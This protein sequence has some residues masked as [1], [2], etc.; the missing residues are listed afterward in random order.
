MINFLAYNFPYKGIGNLKT[1]LNPN[2][3]DKPIATSEIWKDRFKMILRYVIYILLIIG[4]IYVIRMM[5][6]RSADLREIRTSIVSQGP[7]LNTISATGTIIPASEQVLTA[8]IEGVIRKVHLTPGVA[9]KSGDAIIELDKEFVQLAYESLKD[10]LEVRKNKV[11]KLNLEFEKNI[12]DLELENKIKGLKLESLETQLKDAKKLEDIGGVTHEEVEKAELDLQIANLEKLQLENDLKFRKA[13]LSSD[14]RNLELDIAIQEKKIRELASKLR[15][16]EIE[17]P[18]SS[19]IT[20]VNENIGTKVSEGEPLVRL[21]DLNSFR[22]EASSSDMHAQQIKIN[23]PVKVRIDKEEL[24]GYISRILPEVENNTIKFEVI[25][26]DPQSDLLKANLRVEVFIIKD[27]KNEALRVVNGPVFRGTREQD[28]FIKRR[29][30]AIKQRVKVG[31][32]NLDYVEILEGV[33]KGDT[34]I[35]SELSNYQHL[36]E[37]I[38]K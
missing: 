3:M 14:Q 8:P 31:I 10:E 24:D 16:S 21:A 4:A 12:N 11:I 33:Q 9:V 22:I 28:I 13:S 26:T 2:L 20:W 27:Q 34:I 7:I 17:A 30:K 37:F 18:R 32:S 23:M 35:I 19:V 6:T 25:L 15:E 5:L 38:L 1:Q 36:N 29:N